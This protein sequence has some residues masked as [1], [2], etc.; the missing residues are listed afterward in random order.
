MKGFH[1]WQISWRIRQATGKPWAEKNVIAIL[2]C[3][4]CGLLSPVTQ[5][6]KSHFEKKNSYLKNVYS[7]RIQFFKL[8]WYT[9]DF[10]LLGITKLAILL[11]KRE[12]ER[13]NMFDEEFSFLT[14]QLMDSTG[15]TKAVGWNAIA[16]L[17]CS[18]HGL[19]S[20]LTQPNE[21]RTGHEMAVFQISWSVGIACIH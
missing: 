13:E 14:N 19:W 11:L 8:H 6:M 9:R 7:S 4:Q 16:F 5:Q 10:T 18:Q 17:K 20:P 3:S 1:F 2:K 21:F 12:R 15:D